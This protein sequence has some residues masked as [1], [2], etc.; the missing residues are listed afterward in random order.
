MIDVNELRKGVTFEVDGNLF[1][2]LQ[3]HHH[4]PVSYT[5]LTLPTSD[6]V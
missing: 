1:K 2:V 3:Y 4:K 6:L 5:H